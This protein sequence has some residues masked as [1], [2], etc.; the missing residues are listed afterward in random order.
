MISNYLEFMKY[1]VNIMR[2]N[3]MNKHDIKNI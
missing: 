3:N 2:Q 1:D